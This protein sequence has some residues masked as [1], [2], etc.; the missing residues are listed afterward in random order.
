M[1]LLKGFSTGPNSSELWIAFEVSAQY[2]AKTEIP[3]HN[4]IL[5]T[6][7]VK[8]MRR[9]TIWLLGQVQRSFQPGLLTFGE[10]SLPFDTNRSVANMDYR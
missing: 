4:M 3:K 9:I 7:R 1:L 8:A 2:V 10:R 5:K 6:L